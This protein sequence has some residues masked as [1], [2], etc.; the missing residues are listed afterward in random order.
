MYNGF[1]VKS[2]QRARPHIGV[3]FRRRLTLARVL[4]NALDSLLCPVE[5]LSASDVASAGLM[6]NISVAFI[7]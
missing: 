1:N 2:K 6:A 3:G 7:A 4:T 5:V